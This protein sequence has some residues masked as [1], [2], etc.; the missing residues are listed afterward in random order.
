LVSQCIDLGAS[1]RGDLPDVELRA[2]VQAEAKND[3]TWFEP[4]ARCDVAEGTAQSPGSRYAV[5]RRGRFRPCSLRQEECDGAVA[6]MTADQPAGIDDAAVGCS[7]QSSPEIEV[8]GCRE[9]SS[10]WGG[11][12]E[13]GEEDGC[14]PPPSLCDALHTFEVP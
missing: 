4:A 8:A 2:P 6:G 10:E 3:V 5:P 9:T 11:R 14:G 7:K 13:I 12:F 1:P